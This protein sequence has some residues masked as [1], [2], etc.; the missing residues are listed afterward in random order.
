MSGQRET[1]TTDAAGPK[2]SFDLLHLLDRIG[3]KSLRMQLFALGCVFT[4]A[5]IGPLCTVI[6]RGVAGI[7]DSSAQLQDA[8]G[9]ADRLIFASGVITLAIIAVLLYLAAINV[10]KSLGKQLSSRQLMMDAQLEAANSALMQSEAKSTQLAGQTEQLE[11]RLSEGEQRLAIQG[12]LLEQSNAEKSLLSSILSSLPQSVFAKS[13]NGV[14]TFANRAFCERTGSEQI[15]G[16]LETDLFPSAI[17]S[18]NVGLEQEVVK[19]G[20]AQEVAL[21]YEE[22]GSQIH[23]QITRTAL[24]DDSGKIVGTAGIFWDITERKQAEE[25]LARERD[26]LQALM[27]STSDVIYFKDPQSRFMRINKAHAAIFGLKDPAEAV[28]KSDFDYFTG[29]HA[30]AAFDDEQR[31][32]RTGQPLVGVEER[33]TW[34]DKDDTWVSTTKH[35]LY[36]REG[37]IIGTFGITRDITERKRAA[38]A[39]Q[40]SLAEF[41]E[42]VSKVSEGNLILRCREGEETLGQVSEAINRMLDRFGAMLTEVK[43]LGLSLSSSAT[44]ILVAAEQ[45]ALGT[46]QQTQETANVTSSVQEMA[47]SMG[48]VSKNAEASAEAARKALDKAD[49]GARSVRDTSEAMVRINSAVEQTADKMRLL[50]K[51]SSEISEIMGLI[52]GIAAQTNLLALNAAIE[53]AHAG[54][55]GLGFSVVAEEIRKLADR[56]VQATRDVGNLI[57]GIQTETAEALSAMEN[58]MKEVKDGLVLAEQ[59][60]QALQDVSVV[61]RQSTEL[62]E[63][64]FAASEEQTRV[65]VDLAGAMQ[66]ISSIAMQASAGA[67]QTTQII[68]GMVGLSDKLNQSIS[69]FKISADTA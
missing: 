39:L 65:N 61:L 34:A 38:E 21:D 26:L 53:A 7:A 4:A 37:K 48:Q 22:G 8:L 15:Q 5:T 36:D 66:T 19:T 9:R 14:Y 11:K 54:E 31:I 63:E 68:Q 35:P 2:R 25:A 18:K 29:E 55:A 52:N 62:A 60:R 51:R 58:G 69:Q 28:G 47:A 27:N 12:A 24:R 33:E 49:D 3:F 59:S 32:I 57:Q 20:Q 44:Q 17:A 50:E 23:L 13:L 30:Q 46:Q 43:Q 64:I 45:I 42:F 40:R 1:L 67:H 10:S 41:L 56:S 6:S 16:K